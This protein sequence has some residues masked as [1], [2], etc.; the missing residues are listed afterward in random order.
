MIGLLF[1]HLQTERKTDICAH[2]QVGK[3]RTELQEAAD[4]SAEK[5]CGIATSVPV[6]VFFL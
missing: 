2:C 6:P 1:L 4:T 3:L 5:F